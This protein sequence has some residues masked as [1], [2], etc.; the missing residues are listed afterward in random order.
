MMWDAVLNEGGLLDFMQ[1][2]PEV[3]MEGRDASPPPRSAD[4]I[5]FPIRHPNRRRG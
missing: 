3:C 1:R 2:L 5:P 4:V